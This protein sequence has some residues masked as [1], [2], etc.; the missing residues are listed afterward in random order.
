M[1]RFLLAAFASSFLVASSAVALTVQD[2]EQWMGAIAGELSGVQ[3]RGTN[4]DK[5]RRALLDQL[6]QARSEGQQG[7]LDDSIKQ[8]GKLQERAAALTAQGKIGRFEGERLDNLTEAAR[9]C[10]ETVGQ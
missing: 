1:R 4:G 2:C 5:D 3:I 7:K 6:N 9:R 8:V 10:L